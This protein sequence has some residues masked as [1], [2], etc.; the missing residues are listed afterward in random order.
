MKK[1]ILNS[2]FSL[3]ITSCNSNEKEFKL[4]QGDL[5]FQN[6][7]RSEI[8]TAIKDVTA[9]TFSK[10]YSHVGMAI[11]KNR[12]WFV[13]E[14]IPKVGVCQTPIKKFL[15][16]N[17]NKYNKSQTSVAR[18][19]SYYQRYITNAIEYGIKRINKPYDEIFLWDDD[20]YYCSELIYKMFST[21]DLP[22]DSI[23]FLTHPITFNDSTGKP[24]ASWVAYYKKRN[25]KIP[26][27][28]EGTNPN[29]M[30]SSPYIKF[31]HDYGN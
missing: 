14:A 13:L 10:N 17:K 23:P 20:S 30:A 28:I 19:N 31:V 16:R 26:E 18:L 3:L 9:T 27:G 2:L 21:Q 5:L 25:R 1:I 11:R 6:S 4:K 8:A 12:Q 7:G 15:N 24:L 29:L 22:K